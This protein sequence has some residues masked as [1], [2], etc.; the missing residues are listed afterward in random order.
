VSVLGIF[1]NKSRVTLLAHTIL[2]N[3]KKAVYR[4][5]FLTRDY[6]ILNLRNRRRCQGNQKFTRFHISMMLETVKM[7]VL[8]HQ[9]PSSPTKSKFPAILLEL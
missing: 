8:E 2:K 4:A 5:L 7:V 6:N 3:S 1:L 9:L